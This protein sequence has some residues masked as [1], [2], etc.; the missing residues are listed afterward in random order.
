M[1]ILV[2][3]VNDLIIIYLISSTQFHFFRL[4]VCSNELNSL[5]YLYKL[6]CHL[7]SEHQ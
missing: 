6:T 3:F 5:S 4:P 1:K 2:A 7:K